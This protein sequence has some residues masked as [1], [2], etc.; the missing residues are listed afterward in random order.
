MRTEIEISKRVNELKENL[1]LVKFKMQEEL[2]K[3]HPARNY[4]F[5]RFLNKE[6]D[7]WNAALLQMEWL[8]SEE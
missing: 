8:L 1:E 6:K 5:L 4:S 3:K 7:A 2:E